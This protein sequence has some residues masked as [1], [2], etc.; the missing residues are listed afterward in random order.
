MSYQNGVPDAPRQRGTERNSRLVGPRPM[1]EINC[2]GLPLAGPVVYVAWNGQECLYVGASRNGCRRA[3]S[4]NTIKLAKRI[5][6]I[7][8]HSCKTFQSA[9]SLEQQL[10]EKFQPKLSQALYEIVLCPKCSEPARICRTR[11]G[12]A[13][14]CNCCGQSGVPVVKTI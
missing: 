12:R 14:K 6:A 11:R 2:V 8:F 3:F 5:T 1:V 7:Q 9:L 13:R 10:T 4:N